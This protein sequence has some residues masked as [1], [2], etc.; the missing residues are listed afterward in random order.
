M[1]KKIVSMCAVVAL[2]A[3]AIGGATLAYYTDTDGEVNVMTTGDVEISQIENFEQESILMPV[4]NTDRAN[5]VTKEVKVANEGNTDAYVRTLFAFE[6]TWDASALVHCEYADDFYP[7][8]SFPSSGNDYLQFKVTDA[9]GNWTVYTVG[10]GVYEDAIEAG[11][12]SANSLQKVW[13][14]SSADE[15]WNLLVGDEYTILVLSQACQTTGFADAA[16][17]LNTTFGEITSASDELVAS[18][19]KE[20]LG[21]GYTVEKFDYSSYDWSQMPEAE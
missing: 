15:S 7:G 8:F 10:Y 21:D 14:D 5:A 16:T 18:W 12:E 4:L 6:D 1:K 9:N 3:V 2:S 20:M 13:L 17:A 11:K 19:F